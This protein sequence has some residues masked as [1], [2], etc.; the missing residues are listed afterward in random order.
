MYT[1]KFSPGK[2]EGNRSQYLAEVLHGVLMDGGED[3]CLG[4]VSDFGF[5]ALIRGSKY[6]FIVQED[7]LG[8]FD[9]SVYD[10][11]DEAE[12][13]WANLVEEYEEYVDVGGV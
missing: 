3:E 6:T 12:V 11:E 1:S 7:E 13:E 4:D 2:F 10:D 8:F 5:Y 9:V